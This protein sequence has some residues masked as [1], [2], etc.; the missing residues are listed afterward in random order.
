MPRIITCG[1]CGRKKAKYARRHDLDLCETCW[2]LVDKRE[3]RSGRTDVRWL[4]RP[5][6]AYKRSEKKQ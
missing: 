5:T 2:R 6:R 3:R 1:R 4:I